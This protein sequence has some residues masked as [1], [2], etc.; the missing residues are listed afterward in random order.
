MKNLVAD[1]YRLRQGDVEAVVRRL[2]GLDLNGRCQ[3]G[4]PGC[5]CN[6]CGC[7]ACK[8][9]GFHRLSLYTC[10]PC[11]KLRRKGSPGGGPGRSRC[12]QRKTARLLRRSLVVLRT[13]ACSVHTLQK[14]SSSTLILKRFV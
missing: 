9:L 8:F 12:G 6:G 5:Q 4:E 13:H 10:N 11:A 3:Y 1:G 14:P 2:L 7:D